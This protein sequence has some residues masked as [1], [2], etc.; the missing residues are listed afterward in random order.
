VGVVVVASARQTA[1]RRLAL[2]VLCGA[3]LALVVAVAGSISPLSDVLAPFT[4]HFMGVGLAASLG[5]LTRRLSALVLGI[6]GTLL[7]HAWLSWAACCHPP[8]ATTVTGGGL[9]TIASPGAAHDLAIVALRAWHA[10]TH[11]S[12]FSA[13]LADLD[14]DLVVLSEFGASE[15]ALLAPLKA[16]HPF[17]IDC[18]EEWACSLALMSRI[19][20]ASAGTGQIAEGRLAFVWAR[21]AGG[22]TVLGTR[23]DRPSRDPWLHEQQ[24][25]ELVRFIDRL[26]GPVI[27]AGDLNT[28]P[29]SKTYRTLRRVAGLVPAST[30]RP[31]WPAWPLAFPQVALD[32]IF[33]SADLTVSA[34]GTGPAVGSDHLPIWAVVQ[35][36]PSFDRGKTATHGFASRSAPPQ[37]HFSTQLLADFGGEHAGARDLR[38]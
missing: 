5:L 6:L 17:Q 25:L 33:V 31:T 18:A 37:P 32:H 34:A 14:A 9:S 3:N 10:H 23:L 30:L 19:P 12:R 38:R 22:V 15:R 36:R 11:P 27:L 24:M 7:V 1:N 26:P 29:W 16:S 21:L 8:R 2:L 4:G 13:Y 35:R 20:F 28:T